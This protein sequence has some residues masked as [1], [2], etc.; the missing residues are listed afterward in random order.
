[1]ENR[2]TFRHL[3]H[4]HHEKGGTKLGVVEKDVC[5]PSEEPYSLRAFDLIAEKQKEQETFDD[6]VT[7]LKKLVKDCYY[8]ALADRLLVDRIVQGVHD[9]QLREKYLQ[10]KELTLDRAIE[11]GRTTALSRVQAAEMKPSEVDRIVNRKQPKKT[12]AKV[13]NYN[14]KDNYKCSN[15]NKIN[16]FNY[17]NNYKCKKCGSVHSQFTCPAFGKKKCIL[18]GKFKQDQ[19]EERSCPPATLSLEFLT[20]LE[21]ATRPTAFQ[22]SWRTI[23]N[24][25]GDIV[26]D[27]LL[28]G[29]VPGLLGRVAYADDLVLVVGGNSRA[30]LEANATSAL[31]YVCTWCKDCS[32]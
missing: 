25:C 18:R 29:D 23:W 24:R 12:K 21:L 14:K 11:L 26:F 13:G 1:M 19:L 30:Q 4:V 2:K 7:E 32:E 28:A 3:G 20:L 6:F 31:N 9:S 22:S 17:R 8:G 5:K 16:N 10:E 15:N 27:D